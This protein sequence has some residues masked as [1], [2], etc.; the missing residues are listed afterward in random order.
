MARAKAEGESKSAVFRRYFEKQPDLLR[1]K[2]F[3]AVIEMFKKDNPNREFGDSE[4][5]VAAN[6]KSRMRK[7]LGIRGRRRKRRGAAAGA[8]A[9]GHEGGGTGVARGGRGGGSLHMLEE[10]IDDCLMAAKRLDR[11]GLDDVIK[12]LRRARNLIVVRGGG[13]Q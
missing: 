10:Q 5:Q 13:E 7:E 6:I 2:N 9:G 3:D 8:A 1:E 12:H 11:E 4:R